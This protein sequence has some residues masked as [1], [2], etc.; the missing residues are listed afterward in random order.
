MGMR[1][2]VRVRGMALVLE[3]RC[4]F[5]YDD[6]GSAMGYSTMMARL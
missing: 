3:K 1:V 6:G 4:I 5:F 2:R